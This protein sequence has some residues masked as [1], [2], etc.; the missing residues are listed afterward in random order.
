MMN[1]QTEPVERGELNKP[2][3][4]PTLGCSIINELIDEVKKGGVPQFLQLLTLKAKLQ[5]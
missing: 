5:R 2:R 1:Q 4:D 3:T